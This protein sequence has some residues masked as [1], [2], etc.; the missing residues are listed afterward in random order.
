MGA[1]A[2]V[3]TYIFAPPRP[4]SYDVDHRHFVR[5][6]PHHGAFLVSPPEA[7]ERCRGAIIYLHANA[8][9]CN[10]CYYEISRLTR[11][12]KMPVL[13]PEY[14][15]YG[16]LEGPPSIEGVNEAVYCGYQYARDILGVQPAHV[17]LYGRSLGTGA[18]MHLAKELALRKDH[19]GAVVLLSPFDSLDRLVGE[20]FVLWR[21]VASPLASLLARNMWDNGDALS[22]VQCPT[23][24]LHG[25]E[26]TIIPIEHAIDLVKRNPL[27]EA[28][29]VAQWKHNMNFEELRTAVGFTA[30]FLRNR[31][32]VPMPTNETIREAVLHYDGDIPTSA[33]GK[34]APIS[35]WTSYSDDES[36]VPAKDCCAPLPISR[37]ITPRLLHSPRDLVSHAFAHVVQEEKQEQCN[38]A[39]AVQLK[40]GWA[41]AQNTVGFTH[42]FNGRN[43]APPR[44]PIRGYPSHRPALHASLAYSAPSAHTS[45]LTASPLAASRFLPNN[46]HLPAQP[47]THIP[48]HIQ[49]LNNALEQH[50][51][52]Q[53]QQQQWRWQQQ[54]QHWQ[55]QQQRAQ[56]DLRPF[57]M[58]SFVG[59]LQADKIE[60]IS[61]GSWNALST[62]PAIQWTSRL[63]QANAVMGETI[64][65]TS[66]AWDRGVPP[67]QKPTIGASTSSSV[68]PSGRH[69]ERPPPPSFAWATPAIQEQHGAGATTNVSHL[70]RIKL[71]H[72]API[73]RDTPQY[74]GNRAASSTVPR[75]R[76]SWL[77][78]P[79]IACNGPH[80]AQNTRAASAVLCPRRLRLEGATQEEWR[81]KDAR[82][83]SVSHFPQQ[84]SV[85]EVAHERGPLNTQAAPSITSPVQLHR[86]NRVGDALLSAGTPA[87]Q[88]AMV[89]S[90][91]KRQCRTRFCCRERGLSVDGVGHT[92]RS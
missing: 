71:D 15:G 59:A 80:H 62:A 30:E 19:I 82:P 8:C 48:R 64:R 67:T 77:G 38:V 50:Q 5:T 1:V 37:D 51:Q 75:R 56:S 16:P 68:A 42:Q 35:S 85:E 46:T 14:P 25:Q 2:A 54:Q 70:W 81:T 84:R 17:V 53:Q 3:D 52:Q 13:A 83:E 60:P 40:H 41:A 58:P 28:Q 29:F 61:L 10:T 55:Q 76:P 69:V 65:G 43:G 36:G 73:T 74:A 23:L 88:S 9:D 47:I 6:G 79:V 33:R 63:P 24:I 32:R 26:D 57:E 4:S 92:N 72:R 11:K 90:S 44:S 86:W 18:A 34:H 12:T 21:V 22:K 87:S 31:T 91:T 78:G 20:K 45:R 66:I 49:H 7:S 27:A 39:A 89:S